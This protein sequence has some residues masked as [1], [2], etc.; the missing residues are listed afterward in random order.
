MYEHMQK[1]A[2]ECN[3]KLKGKK[4]VLLPWYVIYH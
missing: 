2:Y 1:S 3:F 4:I